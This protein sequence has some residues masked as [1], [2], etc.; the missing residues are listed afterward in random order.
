[1]LGSHDLDGDLL[2]H[3]A[4]LVVVE[5]QDLGVRPQLAAAELDAKVLVVT[6]DEVVLDRLGFLGRIIEVV[7]FEIIVGFLGQVAKVIVELRHRVDCQQLRMV[8]RQG[9]GHH[10]AEEI[11]AKVHKVSIQWLVVVAERGVVHGVAVGGH[12]TRLV[13]QVAVD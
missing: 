10:A 13:E 11:C 2:N 5:R 4:S 7:E 1:M 3:K 12:E 8:L 9:L 6:S